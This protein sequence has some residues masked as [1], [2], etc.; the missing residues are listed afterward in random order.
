MVHIATKMRNFLLRSTCDK[1]ILPFGNGLI[2]VEHLYQ[3]LNLFMKDK[4]QLTY[5]TLNP[6]DKQNFKSVLRICSSKVTDLLRDHVKNSQGTIQF[7]QIMRDIIDGFMEI[8]LT[9]L[10]RVRK[11]W[12]AL[13]LIRIWRKF[14]LSSKCYTLEKNFLSLNCYTC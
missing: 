11:I 1:K 10:Q 12:Y 14:I 5:S 6:T 3:L 8:N 4:H 7:L 2:R 9:P 13:F